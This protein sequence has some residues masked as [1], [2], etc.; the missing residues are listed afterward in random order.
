MKKIFLCSHQ[1]VVI[2]CNVKACVIKIL[3]MNALEQVMRVAE[4]S[5]CPPAG[6]SNDELKILLTLHKIYVCI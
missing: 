5:I 6:V 1:W 4:A 2:V 3:K